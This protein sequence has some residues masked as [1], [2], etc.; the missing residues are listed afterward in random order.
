MSLFIYPQCIY[1]L[2]HKT[3]VLKT[4]CPI[5]TACRQ[6]YRPFIYYLKENKSGLSE[7]FTPS[8]KLSTLSLK[9]QISCQST[10]HI[11]SDPIQIESK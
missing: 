1:F 5:Q 4:A 10:P 3:L 2:V 6:S 7:G 11:L 9:S 8:S